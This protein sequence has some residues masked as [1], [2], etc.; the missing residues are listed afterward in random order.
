MKFFP[1]G[2][3]QLC[4]TF[5]L[6]VP[7]QQKALCQQFRKE[8]HIRNLPSLFK[9]PKPDKDIVNNEPLGLAA[10]FSPKN[11]AL[12]EHKASQDFTL[13][14]DG[15]VCRTTVSPKHPP[16]G[17]VWRYLTYLSTL[18]LLQQVVF[19]F[20]LH[21]AMLPFMPYNCQSFVQ[22]SI[23]KQGTFFFKFLLRINEICRLY[24]ICRDYFRMKFLINI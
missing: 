13:I 16:A 4:L 2:L 20:N 3:G 7:C 22:S 21:R 18:V 1:A 15:V 9:K 10:L 11:D 23:T 6:P 19:S 5:P 17:A 14:E 24:R 12:Q 8:V